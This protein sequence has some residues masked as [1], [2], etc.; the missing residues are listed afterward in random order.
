MPST[1]W[2]KHLISID[3]PDAGR[4]QLRPFIEVSDLSKIGASLNVQPKKFAAGLIET[5]M[6]FPKIEVPEILGWPDTTLENVVNAWLEQ[7]S[8]F[9]AAVPTELPFF[10]GLQVGS[11]NYLS[12]IRDDLQSAVSIGFAEQI[13]KLHRIAQPIGMAFQASL[14]K[15]LDQASAAI[16]FPLLGSFF[17]SLS[18]LTELEAIFDVPDSD[19]EDFLAKARYQLVADHG[20]FGE[21]IRHRSSEAVNQRTRAAVSTNRLLS[22]I[23]R[24]DFIDELR[25]KF[26]RSKILSRRKRIIEQAIRAHLER[27]YAVSIPTLLAQIEGMFTDAIVMKQLVVKH[28]GEVFA[29]DTSGNIK[30]DR[31]GRPVRLYSLDWKVN[32]ASFDKGSILS[33]F[34]TLLISS[35]IGT[36]NDILHGQHVRYDNAGQS[37]DLVLIVD[38]LATELQKYESEH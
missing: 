11:R 5:V 23:R 22:I 32:N 14:Q 24:Q 21:L 3:V 27:S 33:L 7:N 16:E 12:K 36:R 4:M 35:L 26:D 18:D 34:A 19:K 17:E 28:R 6:D 13:E 38:V 37:A 31:N 30:L 15:V 9:R 10:E 2:K 25:G 29:K 20:T 8:A 1:R